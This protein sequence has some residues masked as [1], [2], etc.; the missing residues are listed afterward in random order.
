M[1]NYQFSNSSADLAA[2]D[3]FLQSH[4]RGLYNQ[5]SDW[6][7]S[8]AS[9]GFRTGFVF[10]KDGDMLVG[11]AGY[12]VAQFS[13]F[14][15]MV[16]PCGPV[17]LPG[18]E[19]E[20]EPCI[21]KLHQKAKET[22][23][24][25]FQIS[26][27]L[28][29]EHNAQDIFS[30]HSLPPSSFFYQGKEGTRFKFV[31]PLYG[32]RPIALQEPTF[33]G[34]RKGYSKNHLRNVVKGEKFGLQFRWITHEEQQLL[35]AAYACFEQNAKDKGYPIRSFDAIGDTLTTYLAKGLARIGV[36]FLG[37]TLVGALYVMECGGRYIYINGG[38]FKE[39][40]DK[41]VSH[42]MHDWVIREAHQK[43]HLHYDISVGGSAGVVRFKEGFGSRLIAFESPRYWVLNRPVFALYR[44]FEKSIKKH[45]RLVAQFLY[46]L[47]KKK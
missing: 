26:L 25:Y 24:C 27:P 1:I 30:L 28:C 38:V 41:G 23:C 31:I 46:L 6:V 20:I 43:G 40:Q 10:L 44:L 2:W 16:V 4:P 37:K 29:K 13:F 5:Y 7:Q 42:F 21:Q 33:A 11:G 45:K 18:Y 35:A 9:Y 47:K 22:G 32:M 36:C 17:L 19:M 39:H 14:K 15:F 34:I 12:V 3:T 8:Y